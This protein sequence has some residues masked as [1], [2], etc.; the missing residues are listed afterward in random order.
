[1]SN[2]LQI[3][4]SERDLIAEEMLG[5]KGALL[6]YAQEELRNLDFEISVLAKS[7]RKV[8]ANLNRY[9]RQ[10]NASIDQAAA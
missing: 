2:K 8:D 9:T 5:F 6:T 4:I 3:L 7:E 10:I 1:M